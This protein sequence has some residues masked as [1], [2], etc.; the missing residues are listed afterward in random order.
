M[1]EKIRVSDEEVI[2]F[3]QKCFRPPTCSL[4]EMA[5]V[6]E[7]MEIPI[8]YHLIQYRQNRSSEEARF[9]HFYQRRW[10][11]KDAK[12]NPQNYVTTAE[13]EKWH[14]LLNSFGPGQRIAEYTPREKG[15]RSFFE[16]YSDEVL[17]NFTKDYWWRYFIVADIQTTLIAWSVLLNRHP[18]SIDLTERYI[19]YLRGHF[20]AEDDEE[21]L[22]NPDSPEKRR[23]VAEFAQTFHYY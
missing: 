10:N 6:R 15:M 18:E 7:M 21:I 8:N 11:T 16:K 12:N 23:K 20:E 4:E 5:E 17:E 22:Q 2:G 1:E 9:S 13:E 19:S 14:H 3:I